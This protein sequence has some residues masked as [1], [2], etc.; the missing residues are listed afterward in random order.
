MQTLLDCPLRFALV[1]ARAV[2]EQRAMALMKL[3]SGT[4]TPILSNPG[5]KDCS[6]TLDSPVKYQSILLHNVGS[7]DNK[8]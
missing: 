4:L 6:R 7:L 8:T 1:R 5:F 2:P 3:Q